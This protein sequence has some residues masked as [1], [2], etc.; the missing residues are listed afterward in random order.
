MP[1]GPVS[2]PD[3]GSV[4]PPAAVMYGLSAGVST[5]RL[6]VPRSP[7]AVYAPSSADE[8]KPD[9]PCAAI[10]RYASSKAAW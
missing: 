2:E 7:V 10:S 8:T 9:C 1:S 6:V 3:Q 5:E 4:V